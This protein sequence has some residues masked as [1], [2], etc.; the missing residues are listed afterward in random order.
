M[1][2]SDVV[3]RVSLRDDVISLCDSM[4]FSHDVVLQF[5]TAVQRISIVSSFVCNCPPGVE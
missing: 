1:G 2:D 5:L 3:V 4:S